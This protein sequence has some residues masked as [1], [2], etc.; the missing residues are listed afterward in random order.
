MSDVTHASKKKRLIALAGAAVL[1]IVVGI[2]VLLWL[3]DSEEVDPNVPSA[4]VQITAEGFS[5]ATIKIKR[6]DDIAWINQDE[7]VHEVYAD[8]SA[9]PAMDSTQPLSDGDTY[10]YTFDKAGS[11]NY[12]D[13]LNP[14]KYKGTVIVE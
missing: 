5:P 7:S 11:F 6:G 13:P 3:N 14:T 8:Q 9:L 4:T 12:Y 2:A 10:I 1:V